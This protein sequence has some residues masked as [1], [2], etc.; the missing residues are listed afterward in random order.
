MEVDWVGI[1]VAQSILVASWDSSLLVQL[2]FLCWDISTQ[3]SGLISE[4][5]QN[6]YFYL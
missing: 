2:L 1:V 4:E 5:S 3:W 6:P